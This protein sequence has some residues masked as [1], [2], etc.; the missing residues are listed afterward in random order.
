MALVAASI[1]AKT[2]T[3]R[4]L[5]LEGVHNFRDYGGYAGSDGR[6][7]EG[8]LWRSAQHHGASDADL[9]QIDALGLGTVVDLRGASERA[10]SPC[11]RH[12]GF[13]GE[14]ILVEEETSGF[15]PHVAAASG[16]M[17]VADVHARMHATYAAMPY[18]PQIIT[19]LRGYFAALADRDGAHLI[20]CMA[21]KDRTGLAVALLHLLL[22]VHDDDVRA[23]YLLTN[24]AGRADDRIEEGMRWVRER[25]RIP[26]SDA[27]ARAVMMVDA[28]YLDTALAAIEAESGSRERYMAGPLSVDAARR[29][30][31]AARLIA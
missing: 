24:S 8:V 14:V 1:M 12:P 31:I 9:E 26:V 28:A 16:A 3:D 6:L 22:G 2:A 15:A 7:R 13:A 10:R 30:A 23:D 29:D 18:R 21:G 5:P 4:V 20:H 27:A 17:S 25:Y 11:R 19:L